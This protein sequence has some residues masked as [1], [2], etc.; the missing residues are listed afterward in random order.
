MK[1]EVKDLSDW[2]Y[3]GVNPD[4]LLQSILNASEDD[5]IIVNPDRRVMFAN[6]SM[7]KKYDHPPGS[8]IG[9]FCHHSINNLDK[10][11]SAPAWECPLQ[12]ALESR[13][14]VTVSC[15]FCRDEKD[16]H[17]RITGYPLLSPSGD[18]RYMMEIIKDTTVEKEKEARLLAHHNQITALNRLSSAVA[19]QRELETILQI[20]LDNVLELVGSEIGGILLLDE[21]TNSLRYGPQRGLSP[22]H[23]RELQMKMG[24]GILGKVAQSGEPVIVGDVS[25]DPRAIRPDLVSADGM[26]GLASVPLKIRGQVIGVIVVSSHK[27]NRFDM[28]DVV[29]L[30]SIGN[31]L[32]TAIEQIRLDEN[33][34]EAGR[35][36][37][38]LLK[39]ALTAQEQE[40]KRIARELHDET[41]QAIT[42]LTLNLQALVG[43]AEQRNIGDADFRQN[44]HRVQDYAVYVGN[45]IVKLM[46]E[47]RPTLLDELGMS[48]AILRY[49]KDS[50]Q[51]RG[52]GL[53][54]EFKGTDR[55]FPQEVEVTLFRVAQ[56]IIGNV[57]EHSEAKNAWVKLECDDKQC[58]L[59]IKDDGKGFDTGQA[60]H[61]SANGRGAGQMIMKERVD[62][63]GGSYRIESKP[64]R[65]ACITVSVPIHKDESHEENKSTDRG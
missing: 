21:K 42:S 5:V 58:T 57:L 27:A 1:M 51:A 64:G 25:R 60:V 43:V 39:H 23:A 53:E 16:I 14:S 65:G 8:L 48:A 32:G 46:K 4:E 18:V 26:Q 35:K 31:Y 22:Q 13:S 49:A 17:L 63:V 29:L 40:R 20:G 59:Q 3:S 47:L 54:A 38:S 34:A 24:E 56:G 44:M 9:S 19:A 7:M 11:C 50:L 6:I 2:R 12:N 33:L 41:S 45:E 52:I 55:R 62:F 30:T 36:Y 28:D 10:P 37:Q 61:V 15:A